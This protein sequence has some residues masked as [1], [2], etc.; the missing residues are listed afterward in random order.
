MVETFKAEVNLTLIQPKEPIG[1]ARAFD[2]L[3]E[4]S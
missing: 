1:M 3:L 2:V 4:M